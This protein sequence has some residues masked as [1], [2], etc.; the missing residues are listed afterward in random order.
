[1]LGIIL[2]TVSAST[3]IGKPLLFYLFSIVYNYVQVIALFKFTSILDVAEIVFITFFF[4][5]M[6]LK[7]YGLG[8]QLYFKSQFNTFD[9]VVRKG[10]L[11]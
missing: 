4:F 1:M 10:F 6:M 5:E 8:P 7:L 9:C 2:N 3:V 11:C